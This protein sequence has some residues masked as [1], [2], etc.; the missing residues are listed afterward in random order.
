MD[1]SLRASRL[2]LVFAL[3]L[4]AVGGVQLTRGVEEGAVL[5]IVGYLL[6]AI[7]L[8]FAGIAARG[9][10]VR[11]AILVFVLGILIDLAIPTFAGTSLP[12]LSIVILRDPVVLTIMAGGF[13]AFWFL[14]RRDP[15]DER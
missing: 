14:H 1:W 13:G 11:T 8:G 4:A 3:L 9:G 7:V 15:D 2:G 10:H 5:G 6:V 12:S